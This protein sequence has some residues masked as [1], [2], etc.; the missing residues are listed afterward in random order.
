[1]LWCELYSICAKKDILI[2][3][4]RFDY[5]SECQCHP[6]GSIG[7][8]PCDR[9]TGQCHCK[10]GVTGQTCNR[11]L[12]G[13]KQTRSKVSPCVKGNYF[14][15]PA[16][17]VTSGLFVATFTPSLNNA[18]KLSNLN[19][20][21]LSA[22]YLLT[23]GCYMST[24]KKWP[25]HAK[26]VRSR[27]ALGVYVY[28]VN[29]RKGHRPITPLPGATWPFLPTTRRVVAVRQR[30][31]FSLSPGRFLR[32]VFRAPRLGALGKIKMEKRATKIS[33]GPKICGTWFCGHYR[34]F[35]KQ[36]SVESGHRFMEKK[37][38]FT[39]TSLCNITRPP[40]SSFS[41]TAV[42]YQGLCVVLRPKWF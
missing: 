33:W 9:K 12:D 10:T 26:Y 31:S 11:C 32:N 19:K 35:P 16:V 14:H 37:P 15:F 7:N 27:N 42:G 41:M 25:A 29:W 38:R 30:I 20:E 22:E 1:M 28:F 34:V 18:T 13:Y 39:R 8:R 3:K 24:E 2:N 21:G 5:P 40:R 4:S 23:T 36:L 6:I 17:L